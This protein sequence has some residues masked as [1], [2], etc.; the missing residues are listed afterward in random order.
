MRDFRLSLVLG[1][2]G[3]PVVRSELA[4]TQQT[5][6]RLGTVSDRAAKGQRRAGRAGSALARG[7][8]QA[9]TGVRGLSGAL[10]ASARRLRDHV[11]GVRA[12]RRALRE[13]RS[14]YRLV[15][16]DM[17]RTS[18]R[19][20]PGPGVMGGMRRGLGRA[21]AAAAGLG[22]GLGSPINAAMATE[23]SEF[24]LGTVINYDR[25]GT[26]KQQEQ[27]R[28]AALA[29]AKKEA[30]RMA[31]AGITSINQGLD[32]QY[33]LNSAGLSAAASRAGASVVGK[34]A[35]I[36]GGLPEQVGEVLATAY[37][38]LARNM[39]G[40]HAE[41]FTRIGE[42]LSKAQFKFQIRDFSQLGESLKYG[43]SVMSQY[44]IEIAQ[45]VNLLGA[46]NS[47]GLQGSMAGTAFAGMMRG[48]TKAQKE[49]G[50]QMVRDQKG[51]L[52]LVATLKQIQKA[53]AH[54][55]TD[56]RAAAIQKVFGDEGAR[57][58]VPLLQDL[59]KLEASLDDV[60]KGSRGII[61]ENFKRY[62]KTSAAAVKR[63]SG[64]LANIGEGFGAFLL[65]AVNAVLAAVEKLAGAL[66]SLAEAAPTLSKI[67]ATG[68]LAG[69]GILLARR[70]L[71]GGRGRGLFRRGRK[72]GGLAGLAGLAGG[73][74]LPV[75]VTNW[76][77]G[78]GGWD[79]DV[80][81]R[82]GRGRGGRGRGRGK[83]GR[84]RAAGRRLGAMRAGLVRRASPL[85]RRAAVGAVLAGSGKRAV[86][87]VAKRAALMA[88]ASA[89][90]RRA[91]TKAAVGVV[92][93]TV[94][95]SLVKKIPM[96]SLLAGL[97]FGAQRALAGDWAGAAMEVAS[98]AASTVP[99][100]GTAASIAI[101]AALAARDIAGAG[102]TGP[103][104]RTPPEDEMP[105]ADEGWMRSAAP[106]PVPSPTAMWTPWTGMIAPP[107]W[108]LTI[109]QRI[110]AS[111]GDPDAIKNSLAT[112]ASK[113]EEA[114]EKAI[115]RVFARQQRMSMGNV[116]S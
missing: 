102:A 24:R 27:A 91:A 77:G 33:A 73:G 26:A 62:E 113:I 75:L 86:G 84:L 71:R 87:A 55:D 61:D 17:R 88:A 34:V 85:L 6:R 32:I 78:M 46:L 5:L 103:G 54:L 40:T 35:I 104:K 52:D 60:R 115:N 53:T 41:K 81:R 28:A 89:A 31:K 51:Q 94:G 18:G 63:A 114:V 21:T 95:R 100:A 111:G 108:Q 106:P 36:T 44:N 3:A 15:A 29:A 116:G 48:M 105:T 49:W 8:R 101:D 92:G 45:G 107:K 10:G 68:A 19:L 13:L 22:I 96:V 4:K 56:A 47:A 93:R 83:F 39:A 43:S 69:G 25:T 79:V 2:K 30:V 50:I 90:T 110:D 112:S 65:P 20:G 97:F 16:K 38:N 23:M 14:E 11:A 74:A 9:R 42:L 80:G 7:A 1:L 82:R 67:A 98:G 99:G 64:Y 37:N 72:G 109:Q 76:P 59:T 66:G 58:V 12:D 70:F 57:A